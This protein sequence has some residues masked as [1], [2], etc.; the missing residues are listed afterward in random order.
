[1]PAHVLPASAPEHI[2]CTLTHICT[3]TRVHARTP[4]LLF[5]SRYFCLPIRS[6]VKAGLTLNLLVGK[7]P[8]K[9]V[10]GVLF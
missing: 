9:P 1:M 8:K 2:S 10:L 4:P 7:M 6:E 3:P 5:S